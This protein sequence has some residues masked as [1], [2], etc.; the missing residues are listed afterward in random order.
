[1]ASAVTAAEMSHPSRVSSKLE[2]MLPKERPD[3]ER[4]RSQGILMFVDA[5]EKSKDETRKLSCSSVANSISTMIQSSAGVSHTALSRSAMSQQMSCTSSCSSSKREKDI[6]I[7]AGHGRYHF[8]SKLGAGAFGQVYLGVDTTSNEE[9][10]IKIE[11]KSGIARPQLDTEQKVYRILNKQPRPGIPRLFYYGQE[12]P[13][14]ILVME[15]LGPCLE[16]L[17]TYCNRRLSVKT[18]LMLAEQM[19]HV[20]EAL[21]REG[22][23]HRDIK[24]DNFAMGRGK[25]GHILHLVDYGLAKRYLDRN[26]E[27]IRFRADKGFTGTARYASLHTHQGFEQSRRDDLESLAYMLISMMAGGLPWQGVRAPDRAMK[28]KLIQEQKTAMRLCP[29]KLC[30]GCPPCVLNFYTYILGLGFDEEPNYAKCRELFAEEFRKRGY[31]K[32][33]EYDWFE[34]CE[35]KMN[36]LSS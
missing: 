17:V 24:P 22:F 5:K 35:M 28:K 29:E 32:D 3:V 16:D 33:F 8:Q 9:V 20:V 15:L 12:G 26:G 18:C 30:V 11:K 1:M 21:H 31:Q 4:K 23:I 19:L 6:A 25:T 36:K 34:E 14:Y 10:A 27:H 13:F 7:F 2:G